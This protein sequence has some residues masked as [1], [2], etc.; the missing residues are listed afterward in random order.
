M[1]ALFFCRAGLALAL[2]TALAAMPSPIAF[3]QGAAV[4]ASPASA[5][6]SPPATPAAP[7]APSAPGAAPSAAGS[8]QDAVARVVMSLLSYARWPAERDTVRLCVDAGTRYGGKLMEGGAL[9]SG[10]FVETR[11]IDLMT[12]AVAPSCDALYVGM[13][14]DARRKRLADDLAGKPVLVIAEE[15]FECEAGSMFCLNIRDNQVSFRV[16]LD[17]IAR[18]GIHVHPGV[19]QLGRRRAPAS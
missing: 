12:D 6:L 11:R 19:L 2:V 1:A 10:R 17:S 5:P 14:S 9:T 4:N 8:R 13:V 15:D 16:N 7:S 18:S 3:A